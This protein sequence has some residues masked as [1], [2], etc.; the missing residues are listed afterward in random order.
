M[1][2]LSL[3][4]TEDNEKDILTQKENDFDVLYW[5]IDVRV[6]LEDC[7]K[8]THDKIKKLN[9]TA[10]LSTLSKGMDTLL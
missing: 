1:K 9:I 7:E 6:E 2:K 5:A 8:E 3:V 4:A 10:K